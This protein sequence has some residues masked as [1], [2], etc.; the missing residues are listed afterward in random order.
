MNS[1]PGVSGE[2]LWLTV[3]DVDVT[4]TVG[5]APEDYIAIFLQLSAETIYWSDSRT[6]GKCEY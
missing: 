6:F 2:S 3:M 4:L 5:V 1:P